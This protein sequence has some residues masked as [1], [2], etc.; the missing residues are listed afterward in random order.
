MFYRPEE[1]HGLPR[2]PFAAIVAPR[3][4]A[5]ISSRSDRGDNL[6]PYSFFNA[7]AYDP[8]QIIFASNGIKDTLRNIRDTRVFAINIVAGDAI[9]P[10]NETSAHLPPWTDEFLHAGVTKEECLSIDCPRVAG[11]PATLE[12]RLVQEIAALGQGNVII[13]ARVTGVHLRDDCLRDGYLDPTLYRPAAR[14]GYMDYTLVE[15][16]ITIPRPR[17]D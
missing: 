16:V 1:G 10:M 13:L 3:P 11:A 4:I 5:W 15:N 7:V 14:L 2:N 9:H 17:A 8:P 12:C 6:A